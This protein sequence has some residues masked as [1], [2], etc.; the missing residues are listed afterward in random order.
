M[1]TPFK[2][3][4]VLFYDSDRVDSARI[5]AVHSDGTVSL[6]SFPS[7][8][9]TSNFQSRHQVEYGPGVT[10]CWGWNEEFE[11]ETYIAAQA[12]AGHRAV[13]LNDANELVYASNEVLTHA[14]GPLY[15]SLNAAIAGDSVAIAKDKLIQESSWNWQ[16][17]RPIFLATEGQLTQDLAQI[18][19]GP[20]FLLTVAIAL[21]ETS[22]LFTPKIA[23]CL[24]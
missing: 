12:I 22:I 10:G 23:I 16:S 5:T 11:N 7:S 14:Y 4:N 19:A 6:V 15:L 20:G 21:S 1:K 13:I 8:Q 24:I 2:G 18:R 9:K 17:E 3:A